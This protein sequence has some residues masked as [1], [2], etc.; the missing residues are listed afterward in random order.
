M[1]WH[2]SV[3]NGTMNAYTSQQPL[4]WF[5]SFPVLT[6]SIF[7]PNI[8]PKF[9]YK[10]SFSSAVMLTDLNDFIAPSQD[11]VKPVEKLSKKVEITLN[12]CLA[13]S[14]CITSAES[15]LISMQSS[16]ELMN[17][18]ETVGKD[19]LVIY[20]VCAQT[21]ASLAFKYKLSI[22]EI[23]SRL[24]TF[25]KS[26][27][28]ADYV[29]DI[30]YARD[31]ALQ[32]TA[33]EM[34]E[35]FRTGKP[36]VSGFCPGFVCYAEKTHGDVLE[37]IDPTK[38][39]QQVMGTLIK[40]WWGRGKN[41]F[42]VT[43]MPCFDKKLEASRQDFVFD[44]ERE[45]DLVLSTVELDELLTS[46]GNLLSY[47]ESQNTMELFVKGQGNTLIGSEGSS[48]G[49]YLA[50]VM[51]YAVWSLYGINLS[52]SDIA[53]GTNGISIHPGRNN[54]C[55]DVH[56]TKPGDEQPSLVFGYVYGFRNIQ[57]LVRKLKPKNNRK[58]GKVYHFVEI[59]ACPSGCINGGGQ[60]KVQSDSV[61]ESKAIVQAVTSTYHQNHKLIRGPEEN[62]VM[63]QIISEWL[64]GIGSKKAKD[65]LHTNYRAVEPLSGLV[66]KW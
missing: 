44:G 3:T 42:H 35:R 25:L 41:I 26:E 45:V 34:L 1:I 2:I 24:V 36:M 65:L 64:E 28:R 12:D 46:K 50:F 60:I 54:D 13:C 7:P 37:Y 57:N 49:G 43:I 56:Y 11:C 32:S 59:A 66:V 33:T 17:R 5:S 18:L 58:S 22:D 30:D 55:C 23:W 21:R 16:E 51:R 61:A 31:L 47:S 15:V 19:V 20:S 39:P 14:G 52:Y 29:F 27:L 4:V 6:N 9:L 10:M 62:L 40:Q 48:S 38:S 63:N 8:F 53:N